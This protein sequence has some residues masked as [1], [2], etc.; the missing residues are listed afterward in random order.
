MSANAQNIPAADSDSRGPSMTGAL[1]ES[2][3]ARSLR[4]RLA[5]P[6]AA[7]CVRGSQG[8]LSDICLSYRTQNGERL[9]ALD[10]INLQVK[11]GEFVC[12]VGPSGC[13][14]STLLLADRRICISRPRDRFWLTASPCKVRAPTAS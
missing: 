1:G 3:S 6:C 2:A 13:G 10:H 11:T 5:A 7:D 4:L 14:K 8:R 9:L 12:I